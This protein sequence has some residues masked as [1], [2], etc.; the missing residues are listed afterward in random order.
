MNGENDFI[1]E[2]LRWDGEDMKK[3]RMSS[4]AKSVDEYIASAPAGVRPTLENLR[5]A[6][7][8]AAP[9]AE[10]AISYHMPVF[11]HNG[12]LVFF[13]WFENH[14]SLFAVGKTISKK[15]AKELKP[16]EISGTTIHFS[17]EKP[18]PAS[19]VRKIVKARIE[20]NDKRARLRL[21]IKK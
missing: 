18:L 17:A 8:A 9:D 11:K 15:F 7:L 1:T 10:E 20:E 13:A 2:M 3:A 14:C 12:P 5:R 16:F 6:I 4:T 19:L 21:R